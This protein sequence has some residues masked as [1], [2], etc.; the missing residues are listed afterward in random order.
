MRI[1]KYIFPLLYPLIVLYGYQSYIGGFDFNSPLNFEGDSLHHLVIAKALINGNQL[2]NVHALDYPYGLN[3]NNFPV[4]DFFEFLSFKFLSYFCNNEFQVVN[5]YF[6]SS[7]YLCFL[8]TWA[9]LSLLPINS[10]LA[11][12]F[13][14]SHALLPYI[15]Y[16]N[17]AHIMLL[18]IFIAP[19]LTALLLVFSG[20]F[21]HI[22]TRVKILLLFASFLLGLTYLYNTFFV[23][24]PF[25]IIFFFKFTTLEYKAR[26]FF[27]YLVLLT[28]AGLLVQFYEAIYLWSKNIELY[29]VITARGV[30]DLELYALKIRHLLMPI[31]DHPLSV[32]SKFAQI[33]LG[34]NY[35]AETENT[36]A[37]LGALL[38]ICFLY[39]LYKILK[40]A[41]NQ[42][43]ETEIVSYSMISFAF[44]LFYCMVGGLGAFSGMFVAG[45]VRALNR[46]VPVISFLSIVI[47]ASSLNICADTSKIKSFFIISVLV[48]FVVL[49]QV[50]IKYLKGLSNNSNQEYME[51]VKLMDKITVNFKG[52]KI[53]QLPYTTYPNTP[54]VNNFSAHSNFK[55]YLA[56]SSFYYSWP[57][58]DIKKLNTLESLSSG[59]QLDQLDRDLINKFEILVVDT[60]GYSKNDLEKIRV[61][62]DHQNSLIYSHFFACELNK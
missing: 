7:I 62:C 32:F 41:I 37:R 43:N 16:R 29:K 21:H 47:T 36:T 35:P 24:L 9:S 31:T 46:V 8:L 45:S 2:E 53:L 54:P 5:F 4:N 49:D 59:R 19:V 39:S 38:S 58:F 30:V 13:S 14:V 61:L 3:F 22:D 12:I 56:D 33:Q 15:F 25:L 10:A 11:Y 17:T 44:L 1:L 42:T 23:Y 51:Y 6:V 40:C 57:T 55:Y 60:L 27:I 50:P 34:A 18:Y 28:F 48:F 26:K 20:K 52:K